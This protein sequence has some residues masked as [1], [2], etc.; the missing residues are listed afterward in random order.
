MCPG[1]AVLAGGGGGYGRPSERPA[2]LVRDE[3]R[4]GLVSLKVAQDAYKVAL[5]PD[6]LEIL[7]AQTRT[8]RSGD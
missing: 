3:V 6:T 8:L 2:E 7:E 5:D 4:A 1:L